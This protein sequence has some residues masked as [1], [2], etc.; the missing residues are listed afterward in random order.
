VV[1]ALQEEGSIDGRMDIREAPA[2]PAGAG[3]SGRDTAERMALAGRGVSDVART[4]ATTNDTNGNSVPEDD[5]A[6]A[7]AVDT[8]LEQIQVQSND[9]EEVDDPELDTPEEAERRKVFDELMQVDTVKDAKQQ[10]KAEH[11]NENLKTYK[12]LYIKGK[13]ENLPWLESYEQNSEQ[14]ENSLWNKINK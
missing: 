9:S 8:E 1:E 11:P 10:W 5:T 2:T 3:D 4:Y 13:I 12:R 14:N 6:M 7:D